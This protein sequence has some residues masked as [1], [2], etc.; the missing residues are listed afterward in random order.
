[1]SFRRRL[2]RIITPWTILGSLFVGFSLLVLALLVFWLAL[3]DPAPAGIPTAAL[4]IVANPTAT[5]TEVLPTQTERP[6]PTMTPT[7]LPTP[8]PGQVALGAYVEIKGTGSDGLRLRME[9]GL[10]SR[11][12]FIGQES[13]VFRVEDGPVELDGYSWWYLVAPF[14]EARN[15]WAV[16]NFLVIIQNP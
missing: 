3:P 14:D 1:M 7:A 5:P 4:T 13:E 15:G 10:S 12:R 8:L 6:T 2:R 9:P 16:S 11:I